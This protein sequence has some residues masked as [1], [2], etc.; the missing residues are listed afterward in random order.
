VTTAHRRGRRGFQAGQRRKLTWANAQGIQN[1]ITTTGILVDL[2]ADY[3]SA[4]GTTQGITIMRTHVSICVTTSTP[5]VGDGVFTGIVVGQNNDTTATIF[6]GEHYLDWAFYKAIYTPFYGQGFRGY[7]IDL[8][9][10]RRMQELNQTYWLNMAALL[11]VNTTQVAWQART[12]LA[13]P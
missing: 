5:T 13:L 8:K 7:D 2:L 12:L 4:G 3:K 10:K 1:P 6:P 9:S 11:G